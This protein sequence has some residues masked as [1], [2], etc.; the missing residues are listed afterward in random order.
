MTLS[1]GTCARAARGGWLAFCGVV[2]GVLAIALHSRAHEALRVQ[3]PL[4][5]VAP[6]PL[7]PPGGYAAARTRTPS[8]QRHSE[9]ASAETGS[10]R[11]FAKPD[12][13]RIAG[14]TYYPYRFEGHVHTLHSRDARHP[15]L[16]ILQ[17][18]ERLG[19]DAL[20]ITDHGSSEALS[21]FAQYAGPLVP[22][23]GREIGGEFGHAVFWNVAAD[24]QHGPTTTSLQQRCDFA[25][26]HG[27]LLIFAHPGWWIDGN[28]R[29][30][31]QWMTPSAMRRGGSAGDVD[32]IELWN[33]VYHTPLTKLIAAW[34]AL[35]EAGV[36]VPIV[37]D[38]DFHSAGAHQLGNAHNIAWCDVPEPATCLWSA[39]RTGRLVVTDGPYA[40][41]RVNDRL[42]GSVVRNAQLLRIDVNA[43]AAEGGTLRVYLGKEIVQTLEL[44][45][46]ETQ[47]ASWQ[48]APPD[49]DSYVR[50][51]IARRHVVRSQTPVSLLSNPVLVDVGEQRESWR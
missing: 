36:Y 35:L 16:E 37:G 40:D 34:V 12:P 43:L 45:P 28:D 20:V 4:A 33:G 6:Q 29:N 30:P 7:T 8:P 25:H 11:K 22:L 23:I 42:P 27:G 44:P 13:L 31:M 26:A 15:T 18:A 50:I 38:S 32:A 9:A 39:V 1:N 3:P 5:A 19:L 21:D 24:D 2:L 46:A 10:S 49:H 48:I 14:S 51:E 41:L 17:R 47:H